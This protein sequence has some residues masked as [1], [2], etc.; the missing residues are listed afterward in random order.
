MPIRILPGELV[1]QIAAGEVI[2][3]PASVVKELAE[4]ALDAGATR[5]EIDV[6]R[7]GIG[8]IRV[9]DDGS[10]IGQS[11]LPLALARHAT[12]KIASLDDLAAISTLG[13]RGERRVRAPRAGARCGFSG[14]RAVAAARGGTGHAVRMGGA[15]HP[16]AGP[17]RSAVLVRQRPQRSRPAAHERG[18]ARL[19]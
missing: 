11:D 4:N 2:E 10:G 17:A 5:I 18:A 6:E 16:F 12:S 19:P 15:P 8:L 13:F 9:R 7:G 1:D 14:C 3:R